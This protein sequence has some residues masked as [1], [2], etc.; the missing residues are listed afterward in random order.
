VNSAGGL[1]RIENQPLRYLL[2]CVTRNLANAK[3]SQ[4]M[5]ALHG[6]GEPN[7][8]FACSIDEFISCFPEPGQ[9]EGCYGDNECGDGFSCN[10]N[11]ICL[12]PP[13]PGNGNSDPCPEELCDVPAVCYGFCVRDAGPEEC[14]GEVTCFS[15]P[16]KCEVGTVPGI[17]DGCWT[18]NCIPLSSC[19][20]VDCSDIQNEAMCVERADCNALYEEVEC[21]CTPENCECRDWQFNSCETL[22]L[23]P[24]HPAP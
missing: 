9:G 10:A 3:V 8:D 23:P 14:Y 19:S 24:P 5:A 16:P 6:T 15:L 1:Q 13:R 22:D 21:E 4:A 11:E 2:N 7:S 12:P 20:P 17:R 18:G